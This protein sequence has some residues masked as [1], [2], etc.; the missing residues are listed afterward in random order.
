MHLGR[1]MNANRPHHQEPSRVEISR[2]EELLMSTLLSKELYG[3]QIGQAIGQ[4]SE[5]SY[6]IGIGSLYPTLHRLV[7]KGLIEPR[8][9]DE[10]SQERSGARRR[11]YKL[12]RLGVD[13]LENA[14][15]LRAN[16]IAW[17]PV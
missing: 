6:Q 3:L 17:Q 16:L 9:G 2:L 1:V 13:A 14:Q 10:R 5:G 12:T 11:Y 4:A 7:K 8:W 15:R